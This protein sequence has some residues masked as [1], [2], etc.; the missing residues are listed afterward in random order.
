MTASLISSRRHGSLWA[1]AS[2]RLAIALAFADA[3][4]VVLALPQ[5]VVRLHTSISHVSWV[6]TAYNLALIAGT[7]LARPVARRLAGRGTLIAGLTLFGLASLGSGAA[8]S[9]TMLI[10]FRCLQGLG[11]AMLLCASLPLIAA[12]DDDHRLRSWAAAAAVGAAVGPAAGGVLTQIF[13]WRAIFYSQAPVALAAVLA[14]RAARPAADPAEP[15]PSPSDPAARAQ[16]DAEPPAPARP[17]SPAAANLA[18]LLISA[19]LIG[20]LFIATVLLIN[21]WL[22][23]PLGAAGILVLLPV[24]T[25]VTERLTARRPAGLTGRLGAVVLSAG[26]AGLA[27]ISHRLLLGAGLALAVCGVGLGLAFPALTRAALATR[28]NALTRAART[29]AAREGGLV[30]GLVLLTPIFVSQL[31]AAPAQATGPIAQAVILAPISL[32]DKLRLG[33]GL[34]QA[35]ARAPDS[36]LPDITPA[37]AQIA[38]GADARTQLALDELQVQVQ[39]IIQRTVTRSFRTPLLLCAALSLLAVPALSLG[40]LRGRSPGPGG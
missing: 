37:F 10:V 3:S 36:Q 4:V 11:G 22:L 14:A 2:V 31:N 17:L 38:A 19:G 21:V 7:P 1:R 34:Q 27:L 32:P 16:P 9:L 29:V 30:L 28:G 20:A 5:I 12:S 33:S 35:A 25:L 18:L 13:D 15:A 39:A 23:S 6:I 8:A 24:T 26:L 40:R